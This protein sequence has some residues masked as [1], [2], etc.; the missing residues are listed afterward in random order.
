MDRLRVAESALE[1]ARRDAF[2]QAAAAAAEREELSERLAELQQTQID[3]ERLREE[4]QVRIAALVEQG[5]AIDVEIDN[6]IEEERRRRAEEARKRREAEEARRR[7]EEASRDEEERRRRAAEEARRRLRPPA[8]VRVEPEEA[9]RRLA[10]G[11]GCSPLADEVDDICLV[12]ADDP[13]FNDELGLVAYA[14]ESRS[15]SSD[16][17]KWEV[18]WCHT[19]GSEG[20]DL[21]DIVALLE[22]KITPYFVW[23]SDGQY[24][25]EFV[26]GGTV[27]TLGYLDCRD[28]GLEVTNADNYAV[29]FTDF[30]EYRWVHRGFGGGRA[31]L[32]DIL[33]PYRS[34]DVALSS[35]AHEMGHVLGWPHS[36]S[37]L[38]FYGEGDHD[39]SGKLYEYDNSTDIMSSCY[40]PYLCGTPA[41]NRYAS[42][43]IDPVNVAIHMTDSMI[44]ELSPLGVEGYQMLVV[45]L[46]NAQRQFYTLGVRVATGYDGYILSEGVEVYL[47]DQSPQECEVSF[48]ELC[49]GS[50]RR[51]Q[52]YPPGEYAS[53][54]H[55]YQVGDT[56]LLDKIRVEIVDRRGDN[57]TV[58]LD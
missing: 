27:T 26:V 36:Y 9:R 41:I 22:D 42:G 16:T 37:G 2:G 40:Q 54:S 5:E 18:W 51:I 49:W 4:V 28:R 58:R 8:L 32:L 53:T 23:L 52:P 55:V 31:V 12:E 21:E 24:E 39:L 1:E 19:G 13:R 17:A 25:P 48:N 45:P 14:S 30:G 7:A 43:W 50:N 56:F 29:V 10:K 35:V 15:K 33:P 3:V 38:T 47:I 11:N 57:Y 20:I 44:Y 6:I 34:G 46:D